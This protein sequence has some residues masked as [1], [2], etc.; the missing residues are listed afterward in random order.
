MLIHDGTLFI[1]R[2]YLVILKRIS[3][4]KWGC[5][6]QNQQ[7]YK[8]ARVLYAIDMVILLFIKSFLGIVPMELIDALTLSVDFINLHVM[9]GL[10]NDDDIHQPNSE[11][12]QKIESW[13]DC[14][15]YESSQVSI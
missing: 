8:V 4:R 14:T 9:D 3:G 11:S 7:T 15:N 1:I 10:L 6:K 12:S 2:V 5:Q 13:H